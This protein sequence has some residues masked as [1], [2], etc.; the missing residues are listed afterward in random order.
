MLFFHQVKKREIRT[1]MRDRIQ[2][3]LDAQIPNIFE[4]RKKTDIKSAIRGHAK[5]GGT[6]TIYLD[7]CP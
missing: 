6:C 2:I 4:E 3:K 7:H 5:Y 1:E